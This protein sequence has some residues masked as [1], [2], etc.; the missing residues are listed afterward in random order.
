MTIGIRVALTALLGLAC[1][2]PATHAHT[3]M[4]AADGAAPVFDA[5]TLQDLERLRTA[6]A[7]YRDIAAAHAAGFPASTPRCLSD[8]TLGGMGYH[9]VDRRI[10][11]DKLELERPEILLYARDTDGK[12]RLTAVEYVIPLSQWTRSEPPT[13]LGQTLKRSE[14]LKLWYLHVWAW[15]ENPAGLFADYNPKVKC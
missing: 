13:F 5:T 2:R 1:S 8:P 7:A 12:D 15:E 11:D 4:P 9:Y 3:A 6:T 14:Q 10:L